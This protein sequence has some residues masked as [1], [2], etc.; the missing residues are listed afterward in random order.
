MASCQTTR[1]VST[2]PY[3]RLTVTQDSSTD[4]RVTLSW[5][6]EYISDYAASA[7]SA[8]QFTVKMGDKVIGERSYDINGVTGT[9]QILAG[10]ATLDKTTVSQKINFS[11]TAQ[12]NL[13]WS[14]SYK[15]TLSASTSIMI[16]AKTSY[17]VKYNANGGSGAPASQTKWHDSTLTLSSTKPTRT[18]HTF[19][20]WATSST[21]SVAYAAGAKYTNNAAVTLYAI[22]K[23][24][25]YSVNY[26]ANGGTGAPA[27]QT[28]TYGV[29]LTLSSTKPTRT[30]YTFKGWGISATATTV[31]YTSGAK[32]TANA[33]VTL[34]AIWELSY[35]KPRITSA[36]VSRCDLDGAASDAGTYAKV[37]FSWACDR[38]VSSIKIEWKLHNATTWTNNTNVSATGTSG[39][40][41]QIIGD[42][43]LSVESTYNVRI[44]VTDG[45]GSSNKIVPVNGM[46]LP[47]DVK[48]GNKGIA[49]GKPAELDGYAD[50]AYTALF[51]KNAAVANGTAYYGTTAEGRMLSLAYINS[52]N[53]SVFGYGGYAA[54]TGSTA[55]YGDSI[56]MTSNNGIF[57]D[58]LQIAT[59]KV[60]W[61][62]AYYMHES[63]TCTLSS[64]IS[65]QA[66]GIVLIWSEYT[67]GDSVNANFNVCFVPKYFASAHSGKGVALP[68]TTA[69]MYT[70]A[71]K[72]VYISDTSITG[73]VNNDAEPATTSC[74]I[75]TTPK[76]FVLRYVIGV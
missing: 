16:D 63:Q 23:A 69:T 43:A 52:S 33:A 13:T 30:N 9:K 24:N 68:V 39:S 70:V 55:V 47:I 56:R 73:Y 38:S 72:Y 28:K 31:T 40:V 42:N 27:K 65:K 29:A 20:G 11:V 54:Q 2:A 75:T 44:T 10:G 35:T 5:K 62:G 51:R 36:S 66:N 49:F 41:T 12:F 57:V 18:G 14:G 53:N 21:G 17:A 64:A 37:K 58:G 8:R 71:P 7:N 32:Y 76:K 15:G 1:W 6:L 4:T 45:G 59:N 50:F 60:L 46:Q 67:D 61:S 26:N 3:V 34:Y 22:W 19:Q 48:V 25:T 74:G